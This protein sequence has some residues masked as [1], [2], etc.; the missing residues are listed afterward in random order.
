MKRFFFTITALISAVVSPVVA[1][2]LV[3]PVGVIVAK[4]GDVRV[5]VAPSATLVVTIDMERESVEVGPYARYAQKM[6]GVR[7]SLVEK[8][9]AKISSAKISLASDDYYLA[10]SRLARSEEVAIST[11]PTLP[12]DAM[13]GE[14]LQA[15]QAAERAAAEIFRI[16]ALRRDLIAGDLGE[17]FYGGGLD[18][19]LKRL[20][21]EEQSYIELFMGRVTVTKESYSFPVA[22][23]G[24]NVRYVV[25]RFSEQ[26]GV[27]DIS[28]LS[29]EPILLQITPSKENKAE[30]P[31]SVDKTSRVFRVADRSSCELYCGSNL[32][33]KSII[34]LFEFGY[35]ISYS[36]K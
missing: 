16:R 22:L 27:V 31:I 13:S 21:V 11:V 3:A 20:D 36:T 14:V 26:Q 12:V 5:E 8:S 7:A 18:A 34:P 29:A 10:D 15:E 4:D 28:D 33:T 24:E 1:S 30:Q 19:A 32:L 23:E 2:S 35:D 9:V 25:C 6:L 17:G